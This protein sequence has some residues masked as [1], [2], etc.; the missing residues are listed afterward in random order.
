M[1]KKTTSIKVN[2]D[3][4]KDFK[5]YAIDQDRDLSDI[6]EEMIRKKIGE[7]R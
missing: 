2:P 6:L 1:E 5:K 4:W 3:L 7:I